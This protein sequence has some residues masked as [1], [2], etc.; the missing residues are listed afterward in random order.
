MKLYR[1][2]FALALIA[3]IGISAEAKIVL[4]SV[5]TS[6]MVVQ[7]RSTLRIKGTASPNATVTFQVGWKKGIQT[8]QADAK[9]H[10]VV[11][12][13]TPK[14]GGPYTMV[15][16][17]GEKLSIENILVGEVWL[18]SGQSNME[19]PVAGWGKVKNYEE[20]IR[21]ANYPKVRLFQ[22]K[23]TTA[24][25]PQD[26]LQVEMGGWQ[27]C[28]PEYVPEFSSL[29]YFFAR[30]L[31]QKLNIPIGIINTSWGGTPA[32]AWTS[33]E[34]LGTV[35]GYQEQIARLKE[36]GFT[37]EGA[38]QLYRE[39]EEAWQKALNDKD[40]GNVGFEKVGFDDSN[41]K[42][43]ALPGYFDAQL[44]PG[45]DGIVWYR[46]TIDIPAEWKGKD[47]A[48][49]FCAIDDEDI[50]YWNGEYIH[51]GYGYNS[52]RHYTIPGKFVKAGKNEICVRVIDGGGE[53]G[54]NGKAN[55]MNLSYGGKSI[56]LAGEWKWHIGCDKNG[57]PPTPISPNSSSYP[58][59]LYNAMIHPF[60]DFPIAGVIWY[61]GCANVGRGVQYE[62]L[63][64][65]LIQDWR[66]QFNRPDLPFYFV[67]LANYLT[68]KDVQPDSEWATLRESQA[69]ALCLD[70]TGMVT[71][72]D[73]GET[74]D[75][76]PKNKQ[77]VGRRLSLIALHHNYG[78]K[79]AFDAPQYKSYRINGNK[80]IIN[81][82]TPDCCQKIEDGN[83]LPGFI[84]AGPDH[85]F[86]KAQASIKDGV[87]TVSSPVVPTPIAV[88][89]GWADN[90]TCTL[91]TPNGLHV[92]PFRTDSW[93]VK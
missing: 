38:N 53:G 42:T 11:T 8:I 3:A 37:D 12:T 90:P 66:R 88:R 55:D 76:H 6:N 16:N 59:V 46:R 39:E 73:L 81:L 85:V 45:F 51:H 25:S 57:L 50:T 22:V 21:N 9:G 1:S 60:I 4:P 70:K 5:F 32:E 34:A 75:I 23:K 89:Y 28:S 43:Q 44:L 26:F 54:F 2:L 56:S 52:P 78:K 87:I 35:M 29:G 74:Y 10:F 15:F 19:M 48:L 63:F 79:I 82:T 65:T 27:E 41:W 18:G 91:Q 64:Q 49:N 13:E 67:Q 69:R 72:I 58:T 62:S 83:N 47:I 68:P 31:W 93:E 77:E 86:H 80:V 84:V 30:E 14:A 17:D 36:L 24:I 33:A 7:Q 92:A 20:E 40:Q 61:Q 71:N